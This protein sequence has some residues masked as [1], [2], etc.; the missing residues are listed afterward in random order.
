MTSTP[1]HNIKNRFPPSALTGWFEDRGS[2]FYPARK[3][4]VRA[5]VTLVAMAF[6]SVALHV[7]LDIYGLFR[8]VA[9]REIRIYHEE[10]ISKYLL[11]QRY[12]PANFNGL[13]IG[14][15]LSDNLDITTSN[16]QLKKLRFYNGSMMG[17]N[18]SEVRKV[19]EAGIAGGIRNMIFCVSPYQFKNAGAKEVQLDAKLYYGALGSWNL[20]ETYAI[21]LIRAL[22]LAPH[23]FPKQHIN[24][25]GVNNFTER[26]RADDV[27]ERIHQ[28]AGIH[29][30]QDFIIDAEALAEFRLLIEALKKSNV[31]LL[32]YFHPVPEELYTAQ[33]DAYGK[34][35]SL[36][37]DVV[38]NDKVI[39]DMNAPAWETFTNDYTNYIDNGHLSEQGQAK[40][41]V[42]IMEAFQ[43]LYP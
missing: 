34:F 9:G 2:K 19:A 29:G 37:R 3:F 35:E 8:P 27:R 18:I 15:S 13:I 25:D 40:V 24:A 22:E 11:M 38:A 7:A 31:N 41:T 28:V 16:A 32:V 10:R 39:V 1:R 43:Y 4:L 21:A 17:A 30:G 12:V 20:Y 14:T 26:Y 33:S 6:I 36:V 5:G 23:K 42:S